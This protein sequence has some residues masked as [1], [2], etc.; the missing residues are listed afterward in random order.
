MGDFLG[1][2]WWLLVSLGILVT[3]HE[4]GHFWVARRAGVKVLRFS[5][6][7][8]KPL[9]S[10]KD[11]HGTEFAIAPIPLGG[12]VKMADEREG[13]VAPADLAR[14][15]NRQPVGRRMA[16]AAAG[17][18]ANLLLCVALLW[19][20]FVV[21]RP[22]YAPIAGHVE[23]IAQASGLRAGDRILAVDGHPT[24]TWTEAQTA[25]LAPAIDRRDVALGV[26]AP[27]RTDRTVTLR[28]SRLPAGI[29]ELRLLAASGLTPRHRLLPPVIGTVVAGSAADGVLRT[30]DK[31]LAI[32][33]AAVAS[34]DAIGPRVQA[35]GARGGGTVAIERDGLRQ[36][37]R[38]VPRRMQEPGRGSFWA[39]GIGPAATT[40][41]AYD[42]LLRHG[43]VAAVP[44]ALRE[45]GF[46]L[47]QLVGMLTRALSGQVSARNTVAGPITI[48]RAANAFASQGVAWYLTILALL[49][50]GLAVLNLLP[51]PMLDGG[52]LLYDAVELVRGRPLSERSMAI[53]QYVGLGLLAA[54]MGLA[55]YNDI[56]NNFAR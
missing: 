17:P 37:L 56:L 10:R 43:P 6:G 15:F 13:E 19:G 42:A 18:V 40:A 14:A 7:F 4:F 45:T 36:T 8:G 46:Q 39:L 25:L 49:S 44:A 5:I 31:V 47:Q 32:D 26:A 34:F 22:D 3:F 33:G 41:P 51:I 53:G 23:G 54:L 50:L 28:L 1:S 21:G 20:S 38:I 52:H 2:A 27:G 29:D 55:F 24:P 9:W 48:A 30:G 16:I 35:L 12:Y 11:R